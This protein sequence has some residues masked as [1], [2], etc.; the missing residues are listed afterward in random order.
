L[1]LPLVARNEPEQPE[2]LQVTQA[3]PLEPATVK[4]AATPVAAEASP[5]AAADAADGRGVIWF[6]A[7]SVALAGGLLL[8]RMQKGRRDA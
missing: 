6:L 7:F 3:A 1:Y 5:I 2:M 4:A 8:A